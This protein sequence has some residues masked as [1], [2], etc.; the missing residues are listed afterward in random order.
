MAARLASSAQAVDNGRGVADPAEDC[1]LRLDHLQ[2]RLL[3]FRE[4]RP[5]AVRRNN[6]L[7]ATV[8]GFANGRGH[9][10][11]SCHA[12]HDKRLDPVVLQDQL[13]VGF[14]ERALTR[15]VDDG[16]AERWIQLGNDVVPCFAANQDAA[17]GAVGANERLAAARQFRRRAIG[18]VGA[19]TLTRMDDQQLRITRRLQ[20]FPARDNCAA[21]QGDVISQCFAKASRFNKITLH[22]DHD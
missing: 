2:R 22:V 15:F 13:Q 17:H 5:D 9:A 14:I 19:V 1:A 8:I 21:H 10:D 11:F 4:I 12:A 7:I 6:A 3:E 20:H 16:F 18:Q